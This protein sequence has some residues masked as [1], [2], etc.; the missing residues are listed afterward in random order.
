M[1]IQLILGSNSSGKSLYAESLAV[2][3]GE[4]RVYLAT[5]VSQ[6]AENEARIEK[7]RLQRKDKGFQ[8]VERGWGIDEI[9]VP[10]DAVVLLEDA[11]NFLANGIFMH[12]GDGQQALDQILGL[13]KRC[14]TLLVVSISGLSGESYDEETRNYIEQLNWLNERLQEKA[15]FAVTMQ[16]G[17]P[18]LM[19]R[20]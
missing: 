6:N 17:S 11:S 4:P 18:I 3:A 13:A 14:K 20:N 2:A 19:N 5:M 12:G 1:E 16:D 8:T 9:P 7:H 15:A 10:P